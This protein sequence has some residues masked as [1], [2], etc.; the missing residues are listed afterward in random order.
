MNRGQVYTVS[1]VNQYIKM[2]F[3]R[4]EALAV[5]FVKGEISNCKYHSSGHIYFTLKDAS[6]AI[7]CVMFAGDRRRLSF[8]LENGQEVLIGGTIS[9]YERDG[10]YQLYAKTIQHAGEGILAEKYE[11]LKKK[12]EQKGY[13]SEEHKKQIPK[14]VKQVGIV[15][16]KTGAAIQDIINISTRRNPYVQLILYPAK[17]QGEGA[18][19]TIAAGIRI[20]DAMD[21]DVIIVGRGGGSIEDLW[22]FNEEVTAEAI[23]QCHTA[24]HRSFRRW[25]MRPI[26]R[27][28]IMWQICVPRHRLR[29][30]N[31]LFMT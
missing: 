5:V 10:R 1:A 28:R 12:L 14:Y 29:R 13:F 23:Y 4:E 17:V 9:V 11:Q 30:Q 6:S 25:G 26:R 31:L 22:A 21:L 3:Q 18:C 7:S 15:T 20:L 16:A 24:I 19:D 8:R 2:M 27:S